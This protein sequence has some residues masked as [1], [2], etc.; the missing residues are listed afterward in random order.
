MYLDPKITKYIATYI[1]LCQFIVLIKVLNLKR[2]RD[3]FLLH[4]L[5]KQGITFRDTLI[6]RINHLKPANRAVCKYNIVAIR[7]CFLQHLSK[8]F[9]KYNTTESTS[10]LPHSKLWTQTYSCHTDT[11]PILTAIWK[12]NRG[13]L[14]LWSNRE[15][16][17]W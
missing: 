7:F 3:W 8:T 10:S 17:V 2:G 11:L 14:W 5:V 16:L 13:W 9:A 1:K 15:G 12:R 6:P 4:K